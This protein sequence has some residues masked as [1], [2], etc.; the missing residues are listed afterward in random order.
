MMY[1]SFSSFQVFKTIYLKYTLKR[2]LDTHKRMPTYIHTW[3]K[4]QKRKEYVMSDID[5]EQSWTKFMEN[6]K[7]QKHPKRDIDLNSH[8]KFMIYFSETNWVRLDHMIC[9]NENNR[10]LHIL[11][12]ANFDLIQYENSKVFKTLISWIKYL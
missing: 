10:I 3:E 6:V 4:L 11:C 8:L 12:F 1:S 7:L 2:Y 9:Y 5:I